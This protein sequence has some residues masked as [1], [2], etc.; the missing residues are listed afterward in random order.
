MIS[1]Q[2]VESF[3]HEHTT[4]WDPPSASLLSLSDLSCFII[5]RIK[6]PSKSA[7][8]ADVCGICTMDILDAR[9]CA[10][11]A[12]RHTFHRDCILEYS[13]QGTSGDAD[14][15]TG[16]AGGK[17]VRSFLLHWAVCCMFVDGCS[18]L[19][20]ESSGCSYLISLS[21]SLYLYFFLFLFLFLSL[22]FFLFSLICCVSIVFLSD[23]HPDSSTGKA[24]EV[25]QEEQDDGHQLHWVHV[26]RVLPATSGQFVRFDMYTRLVDITYGMMDD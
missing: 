21:L 24:Q 20:L 2:L 5:V 25:G 8:A 4:L 6:L 9:D 22:S 18:T 14:D 11:N 13:Q 7:G 10:V 1:I 17:E 16:A 3:I 12:C 23:S 19:R 15:P 26:P